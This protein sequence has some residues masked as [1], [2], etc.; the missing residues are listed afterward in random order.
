MP[1]LH[2]VAGEIELMGI[3]C[4][5]IGSVYADEGGMALFESVPRRAWNDTKAAQTTVKFI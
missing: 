2:Q 1:E 4:K 5:A 3:R